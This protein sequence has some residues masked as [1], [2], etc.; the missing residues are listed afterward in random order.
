MTVSN[1]ERQSGYFTP[2]GKGWKQIT[3]HGEDLVKALPDQ[4]AVKE[5]WLGHRKP[6]KRRIKSGALK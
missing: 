2:A 1:A 5:L 4:A 3:T 6:R